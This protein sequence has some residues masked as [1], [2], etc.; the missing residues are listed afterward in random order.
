VSTPETRVTPKRSGSFGV[1]P[2]E[3]ATPLAM[4]LT[5]LLQNALEHGLSNRFG[6]LE[7]VA[8]R[9]TEEASERLAVV[10][11]DDGVGLPPEFDVEGTDSL[12]LQ[13][14]RTLTVGE[15]GGR[16][17]FRRRPAGGTE[18]VVDVPLVQNRPSAPPRP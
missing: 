17:D 12:G 9:Y 14:V 4:A 8:H 7:V 2:A 10:V 5:E 6:T 15:L 1:L 16:L 3:I 11:A 13:I 18:V